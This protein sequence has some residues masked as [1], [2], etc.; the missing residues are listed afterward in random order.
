MIILRTRGRNFSRFSGLASSD[1]HIS[2][3][4]R[5]SSGTDES[6]LWW[7]ERGAGATRP[8]HSLHIDAKRPERRH[9]RVEVVS[10]A[11]VH[12]AN[13]ALVDNLLAPLCERLE[14]DLDGDQ[15]PRNGG[16]DGWLRRMSE[17][18][19]QRGCELV[20]RQRKGF[21]EITTRSEVFEWFRRVFGNGTF[22]S[23]ATKDPDGPTP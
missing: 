13:V 14:E 10:E 4:S 23:H 6:S 22:G 20:E 9:S 8:C 19:V 2:R 17:R 7:C 12:V 3:I 16:F 11:D 21:R 5:R 18:W 15:E 1:R